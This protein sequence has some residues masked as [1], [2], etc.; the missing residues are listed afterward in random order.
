MESKGNAMN[1]SSEE[2]LFL[3]SDEELMVCEGVRE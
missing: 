3:L 2:D 1:E